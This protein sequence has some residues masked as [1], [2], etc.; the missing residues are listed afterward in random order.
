M[1]TAAA[2]WHLTYGY[3]MKPLILYASKGQTV[4]RDGARVIPITHYAGPL[5]E[6]K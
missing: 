6:A 2:G 1:P 4:W 3:G 5:L